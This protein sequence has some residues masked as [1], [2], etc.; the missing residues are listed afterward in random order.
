MPQIYVTE[1]EVRTLV[2]MTTTELLDKDEAILSAFSA[3]TNCDSDFI[4]FYFGSFLFT[5]TSSSIHP[6]S[7]SLNL[8]LTCTICGLMGS[9]DIEP[10]N[11]K[12][13]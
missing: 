8:A 10:G 2:I 7:K 6:G 12:M 3:S 9:V 13:S 11:L 4:S 5:R 1:P